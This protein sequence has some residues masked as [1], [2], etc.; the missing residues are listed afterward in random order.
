M[1]NNEVTL[2]GN[3]GAKPKLL[4]TEDKLFAT[5]SL[6][7]QDRYLNKDNEWVNKQSIWHRVMTFPKSLV[8]ICE[9]LDKGMRIKIKGS[10]SYRSFDALLEDQTTVKKQE[11]TIIA[12]HIEQA[13]L[14]VSPT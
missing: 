10:L 14:P 6:A 12:S 4:Q 11:A 13:P 1:P 3:L 5:F 8:D 9:K 7:T 2:I